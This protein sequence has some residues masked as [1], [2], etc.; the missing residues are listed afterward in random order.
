[1]RWRQYL[2][3]HRAQALPEK[4]LDYLLAAAEPP[5]SLAARSN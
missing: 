2:I 1:M 5:T 3:G 4:A